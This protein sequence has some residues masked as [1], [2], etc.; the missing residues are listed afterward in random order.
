VNELLRI[1]S[2][3]EE[4]IESSIPLAIVCNSLIYIYK[5]L[6]ILTFLELKNE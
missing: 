3:T 1:S 4:I 2:Q 5:E 6:I